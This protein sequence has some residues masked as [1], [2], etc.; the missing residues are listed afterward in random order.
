M[1]R[2]ILLAVDATC[3]DFEQQVATATRNSLQ[4][5]PDTGDRVLVLHMHETVCG[6]FGPQRVDCVDGEG[7]K[8]ADA[9]ASALMAEGISADYEVRAADYGDA[10][11][12]VLAAA[13]EY[14]ARIVA[15]GSSGRRRADVLPVR[16]LG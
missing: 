8:V 2:T 6:R 4:L 1:T 14:G 3:R 15:L 12:A 16:H 11:W 10:M 7:E 9:V 13:Q 5:S